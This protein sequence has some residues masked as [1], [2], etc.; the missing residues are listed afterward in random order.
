MWQ[1]GC[2]NINKSVHKICQ[3]LTLLW[4]LR[5]PPV[6][7]LDHASM[8]FW[9]PSL[10]VSLQMP[11]IRALA[12]KVMRLDAWWLECTWRSWVLKQLSNQPLSADSAG[13]FQIVGWKGMVKERS[14][15]NLGRFCWNFDWNGTSGSYPKR[16]RRSG[17][18]PT[19]E[20][21]G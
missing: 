9:V 10:V 2:L 1:C 3:L 14:T 21:N 18:H 15:I 4:F 20:E 8:S 12:K 17:E 19:T 5:T 6:L 7:T 13:S 11:H 16:P